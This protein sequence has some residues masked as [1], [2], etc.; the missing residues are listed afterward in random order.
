MLF[1]FQAEGANLAVRQAGFS[2][3][4]RG[5]ILPEY[6]AAFGGVQRHG[7]HEQKEQ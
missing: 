1:R 4:Y 7:G 2:G 3:V 5:D 6:A